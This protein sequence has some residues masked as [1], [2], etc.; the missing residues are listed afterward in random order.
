V[1]K[2][3]V[4]GVCERS[5]GSIPTAKMEI[6]DKELWIVDDD[7]SMCDFLRSFLVERGHRAETL[8]SAEEAYDRVGP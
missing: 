8:G 1:K 4:T 2:L 3:A 5:I 7:L 6:P